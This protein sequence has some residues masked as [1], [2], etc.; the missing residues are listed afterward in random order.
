M[1]TPIRHQDAAHRA[2]MRKSLDYAAAVFGVE[3]ADEVAWGW[4]DRSI[5]AQVT[6]GR[7]DWWLRV[8]REHVA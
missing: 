3:I 5:G 4:R 7:G 8:V 6:N 1:T 2:V